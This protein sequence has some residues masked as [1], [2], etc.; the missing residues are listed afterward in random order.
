VGGGVLHMTSGQ[1]WYA[2]KTHPRKEALA[3]LHLQRQHFETF[4]P[5]ISQTLRVSSGHVLRQTAFFPGYL[6][7]RLDL[8]ADR[9]R[10]INGTIGV[11]R[12]VEF[13]GR[14]A[15][16]PRGLVECM[17]ERASKDGDVRF[18]NEIAVGEGVRVIGG[19]FDRLIGILQSSDA[20]ERA[21][22]L[23]G[24]MERQVSVSL[25]RSSIMSA[26]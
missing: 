13:G 14:P 1:R 24:L 17:Q 20:N 4:L 6:F 25:P 26:G 15:P 10:S 18:D 9:W 8:S 21:T 23:I 11:S 16:A 7:T 22:V 2:V 3:Q 12:L 5:L 19:P